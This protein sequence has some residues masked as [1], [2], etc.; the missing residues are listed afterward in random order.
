MKKAVLV[1]AHGAPRNLD[2][3]E[4]YVLHIRHGRPLPPDQMQMLKDRYALVGGSPLLCWTEA[5]ANGLQREVGPDHPVYI[6]MRHSHPFIA[7]TVKRMRAEGVVSFAALCMAPQFSTLTIGAYRK[8]LDDAI[9]PG[10]MPY[11]LV[12][13]YSSHP[14]LIAA[15][16]ARL[17]E[18]LAAHPGAF[19]LFTAHSLPERVIQQ[20]DSYDREAKET[21]RLVAARLGLQDWGF[22]FQ[23]QGLTS[24]KWLGPT[25]ESTLDESAGRGVREVV[26]CPIGFVC[27]H[28]E[29]LYDIDVFFLEYARKKGIALFRSASLNDCPE[30]IDLI[31]TLVRERL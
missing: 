13:S 19:V 4:E 23:S 5:Q 21:A 6:G 10:G 26:V 9:G 18:A 17:Q 20:G 29:I 30:F 15:F 3:V 8:A 24:E 2:E 31:H 12:E 22:A 25:V 28:V 14:K 16:A 1:M 7:D 27:D 11:S